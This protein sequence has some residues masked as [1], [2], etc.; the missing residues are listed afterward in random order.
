MCI[1]PLPG[2]STAVSCVELRDWYCLTNV[3]V[4]KFRNDEMGRACG[5]EMYSAVW[6]GNLRAV[7][8]DV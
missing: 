1:R 7:V 3:G 2:A 6:W 4:S 8:N 5:T